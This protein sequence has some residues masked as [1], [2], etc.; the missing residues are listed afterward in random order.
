MA[1]KPHT[2]PPTYPSP[3]IGAYCFVTIASGRF[4]TRPTSPP[5]IQLGIGSSKLNMINPMANLLMNDADITLDLSSIDIKNIG[6]FDTIPKTV[7]AI[8]PL[9]ILFI[10]LFFLARKLL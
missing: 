9:I 4:K 10:T 2:M 7:P 6:I 3:I 1:E 5:L 8:S